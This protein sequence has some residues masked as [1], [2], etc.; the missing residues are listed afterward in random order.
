MPVVSTFVFPLPAAERGM[1]LFVSIESLIKKIT[2]FFL[3]HASLYL[4]ILE[5]GMTTV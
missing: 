3:Y 1:A 2:C 4:N 5:R